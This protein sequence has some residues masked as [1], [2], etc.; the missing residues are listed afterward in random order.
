MF[1]CHCSA[2]VVSVGSPPHQA[3]GVT[4][5]PTYAPSS[6]LTKW[7]FSPTHTGKDRG[8]TAEGDIETFSPKSPAALRYYAARMTAR[9]KHAAFDIVWLMPSD[10]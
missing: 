4:M 3:A 6:A 7:R 9:L 1:C 5:A 8:A 2:R 10:K